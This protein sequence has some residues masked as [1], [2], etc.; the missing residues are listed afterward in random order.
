MSGNLQ[1]LLSKSDN[2]SNSKAY[3]LYYYVR[4]ALGN[5]TSLLKVKT[6]N[7]SIGTTDTKT[8]VAAYKY[9]AY[10]QI[11]SA[12]RPSGVTDDIYQV[13]P[14]RYKDYYYDA[15]TGWYNLG[16]RY[17]DPE[18][19]R[20]I[21][22]DDPSL[23]AESPRSFSDKNLYAYCDNNPVMRADASGEIWHVAAGAGIG[24]AVSF[25]VNLASNLLEGKRGKAA[26]EGCGTAAIGG[27]VRGGVMAATG[28]VVAASYAGAAAESLVRE[29]T[30]YNG[31]GVTKSGV[32]QSA[33]KIAADTAING[34]MSIATGKLARTTS[35]KS[36]RINKGMYK[37]KKFRSAFNFKSKYNKRLIKSSLWGG[38]FSSIFGSGK[39]YYLK[40]SSWYSKWTGRS[41]YRY[42]YR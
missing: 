7:G 38:Y 33:K 30:S 19:G 9:D 4:D 39:R 34:T 42:G 41:Y 22:S 12:T 36:F 2:F 32:K 21:N 40:R 37:P 3:N 18:I 28:N 11:I 5:I 14:I 23:I 17:Y 35:P 10:G 13:N 6:Q 27:A 1:F 29:M 24:A 8:L 26:F 16:Y 25:T 20:F 15:D 31:K